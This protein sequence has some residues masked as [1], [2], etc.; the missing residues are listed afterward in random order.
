M[1]VFW[2]EKQRNIIL[3]NGGQSLVE[4]I[5]LLAVVVSL[6]FTAY[7]NRRFQDFFGEDSQFFNRIAREVEYSYRHGRIS[8]NRDNSDQLVHESF[9]I[10]I[11]ESRFFF[12]RRSYPPQN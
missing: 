12:S 9:A 1:G 6:V 5:L 7:K 11:D 10:S 4:Y 2:M 3:N 8:K